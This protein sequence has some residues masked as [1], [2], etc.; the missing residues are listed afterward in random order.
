[1][2]VRHSG[3]D[4]AG[5]FSRLCSAEGALQMSL[6]QQGYD[7]ARNNHLGFITQDPTE[8]GTAIKAS[9]VVNL[10]LLGR[11]PDFK[12]ACKAS[13]VHAQARSSSGGGFEICGLES[14]GTSEVDMI[15]SLAR[16]CRTLIEMEVELEKLE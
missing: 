7:Y 10:P 9:L 5:A 13:Q 15:S 3:S 16:G 8:L 6:Q 14:L 1:M 2:F 4:L 12:A 11:S